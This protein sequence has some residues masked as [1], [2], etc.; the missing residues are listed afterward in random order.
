MNNGK[1][2]GV[3][4]YEMYGLNANSQVSGDFNTFN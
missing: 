4:K 2:D 1:K 3:K